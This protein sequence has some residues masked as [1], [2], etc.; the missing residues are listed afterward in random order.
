MLVRSKLEGPG[1][2]TALLSVFHNGL[3]APML[4]LR[5]PLQCYISMLP[6]GGRVGSGGGNGKYVDV[7]GK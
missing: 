3:S 4:M 6:A 1:K 5:F 7:S 2:S